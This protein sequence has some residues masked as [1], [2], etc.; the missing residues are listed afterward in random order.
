MR[1]IVRTGK[2]ARASV[3]TGH[4]TPRGGRTRNDMSFAFVYVI[5]IHTRIALKP[6]VHQKVRH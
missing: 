6:L 3:P 1:W 4:R 5:A 2:S